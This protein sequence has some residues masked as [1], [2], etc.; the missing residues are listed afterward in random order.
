ML[1]PKDTW[2]FP[3]ASSWPKSWLGNFEISDNFLREEKINSFKAWLRLF[4]TCK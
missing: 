1:I 2:D 4:V 3:N